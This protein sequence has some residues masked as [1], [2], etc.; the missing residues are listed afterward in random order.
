MFHEKEKQ[1]KKRD[2][3][4]QFRA[5]FK[6]FA[7]QMRD[8]AIFASEQQQNNVNNNEMWSVCELYWDW[9]P[10]LANVKC[11]WIIFYWIDKMR[12]S[13]FVQQYTNFLRF[14]SLARASFTEWKRKTYQQHRVHSSSTLMCSFVDL[15]AW[16][17]ARCASFLKFVCLHRAVFISFFLCTIY[18]HICVQHKVIFFGTSKHTYACTHARTAYGQANSSFIA[19]FAI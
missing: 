14:F 7:E 16:H 10:T 11:S 13:L 2:K 19:L 17:D 4:K 1:R 8:S 6:L 12:F 9:E 3:T 18:F 5:D 15:G